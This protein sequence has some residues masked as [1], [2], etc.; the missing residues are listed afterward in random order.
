MDWDAIVRFRTQMK[1]TPAFDSLE[2]NTPENE[3]FGSAEMTFR[4]FTESSVNHDPSHPVVDEDSIMAPKEQVKLMNPMYYIAD[5]KATTAAHYR[6]CHGAVDRDNSLAISEMLGLMLR[7]H[8]VD[9]TVEH[10]WGINHAGDYNLEELLAW[11]DAIV[12]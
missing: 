5:E 8:G 7:N 12:K 1:E 9:V 6:I 3:L 11:I 4:H 10:P 2:N